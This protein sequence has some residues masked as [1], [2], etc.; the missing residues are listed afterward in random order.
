MQTAS[1]VQVVPTSFAIDDAALT[2]FLKQSVPWFQ[3]DAGLSIRYFSHGQSNPT[4]LVTS[5]SNSKQRLVLRKQPPGPILPSAHRVLREAT[6]MRALQGYLSPVPRI[7][8]ACSSPSVLGTPFFLMQFIDGTVF[9]DYSFPD[10]KPSQRLQIF[11]GMADTLAA[12]HSVPYVQAGEPAL[13]H[14][15]PTVTICQVLQTLGRPKPS[16]LAKSSDGRSS[17]TP[18]RLAPPKLPSHKCANSTIFSLLG[19]KPLPIIA[20]AAYAS[21]TATSASTTLSGAAL[22]QAPLPHTG[23]RPLHSGQRYP[24]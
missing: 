20:A 12:I 2:Q 9:P 24:F 3:C 21:S 4:Y 8:S 17:S 5:V 10:L 18:P 7:F 13:P 22:E 14:R 15:Y 23:K 16:S 1:N 11:R 19:A 6:V